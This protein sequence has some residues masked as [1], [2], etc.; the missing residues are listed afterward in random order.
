MADGRRYLDDVDRKVLA[1][2]DEL[3]LDLEVSDATWSALAARYEPRRAGRARAHRG[4]LLVRVAGLAH[5]AIAGR[6]HRPPP[7]LVVVA[8][9]RSPTVISRPCAPLATASEGGMPD[10]P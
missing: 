5:V 7:R 6:P 3:T 1:M 4:V 2:T 10:C 9:L 8:W